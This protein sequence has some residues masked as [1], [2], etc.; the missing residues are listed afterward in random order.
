VQTASGFNA[1]E[2]QA[3][4]STTPRALPMQIL[5]HATGHLIAL[6]ACAALLRQQREGGSWHVQVSLAAT[7]QWLRG[8]GRVANGFDAPPPDFAPFLEAE[9]GGFGELQAVRP[10]ARL[11]ATPLRFTRPSMPPG[12]HPL[13]WP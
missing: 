10:A 5:D 6:G 11:S 3:R 7:G 12:S 13:A 2:A 1:A 4:G 9:P 8:L